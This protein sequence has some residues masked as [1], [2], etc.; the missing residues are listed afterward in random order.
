MPRR[1]GKMPFRTAAWSVAVERRQHGEIAAADLAFAYQR[2]MQW[3]AEELLLESRR[4][5]EP[6]P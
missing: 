4:Q 5:Q 1:Y 6:K 3:N 2:D